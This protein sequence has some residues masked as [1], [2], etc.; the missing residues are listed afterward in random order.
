LVSVITEPGAKSKLVCSVTLMML[1]TEARGVLCPIPLAV[2]AGTMM[3]SGASP[4]WM[5]RSVLLRLPV[6][7]KKIGELCAPVYIEAD[8]LTDGGACPKTPF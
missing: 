2:K 5:P 8:M 4:P 1:L 6:T 3:S 7:F